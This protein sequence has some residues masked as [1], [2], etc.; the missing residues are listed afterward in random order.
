MLLPERRREPPPSLRPAAQ[1]DRL[2]TSLS[3]RAEGASLR[4]HCG[5]N[6]SCNRSCG[7]NEPSGGASLRLHCGRFP[8]ILGVR[9]S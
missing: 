4:L 7:G 2:A 6:N 8:K 1:V 5:L 3:N 9:E